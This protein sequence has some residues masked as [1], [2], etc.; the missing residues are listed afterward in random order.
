MIR[1][2]GNLKRWINTPP[3]RHEETGKMNR[4]F[5]AAV[6]V[7]SAALV[8]VQPL[9][10]AQKHELV[11]AKDGSGVF[12]Y[13][14]TPMQPWSGFH[15]HDP[16]RPAPPVVTVPPPSGG[17]R[18][19]LRRTR[20]VLFDGRDL[21][22]G[23]PNK[24]KVE[25][26]C[27]VAT[28]GPMRTKEEFGDCQLHLEWMVPTEPAESI[29]NRGNNGVFLLGAIEVQ[30]FDSSSVK[31]YP[32]GQAAAVYAQ[33]PPLVNACRKPGEWQTY[34]IVFVAPKFDDAGKLDRARPADHV[35]QR[36]PGPPEPRDLR[37]HAARRSGQLRRR[38]GQRS[39]RLRRPPLPGPL[40]QHL[41]Q[42]PLAHGVCEPAM[43][44][45]AGVTVNNR[46]TV[47]GSDGLPQVD[48]RAGCVLFEVGARPHQ[49]DAAARGIRGRFAKRIA[50]I[51]RHPSRYEGRG[52]ALRL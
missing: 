13:K 20:S 14:D 3:P 46:N 34:D 44:A 36:R 37:P 24:W 17:D 8:G 32:D 25:D 31:I 12:G 28:E 29:W 7:F 4:Q 5:L 49:G 15:V 19:R 38:P 42:A 6:A 11:N 41:G 26:G 45:P 47:E 33:T 27:L 16:D 35:P 43:A 22:S 23:K 30:I 50:G 51:W 52:A 18:P 39:A 21:D 48:H 40:P 10:R 1:W 9:A 2:T